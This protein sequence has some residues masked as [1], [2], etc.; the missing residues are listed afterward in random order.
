VVACCNENRLTPGTSFRQVVC[1]N[2]RRHPKLPALYLSLACN[3]CEAP[4][5]LENCPTGAYVK[6]PATGAVTIDPEVC[7][8]CKYCT[9]TCPYDAPRFNP[10]K[11]YTEKCNFCQDRLHQGRPPACVAGCPTDALQ[12]ESFEP[13]TAYPLQHKIPG[14]TAAPTKPS[15]RLTDWQPAGHVV[16]TTHAPATDILTDLYNAL[17]TTER[18]KIDPRTEWTLLVFTLVAAFQ[19]AFVSAFVI[20]GRPLSLTVFLLSGGFNLALSTLHLGRKHR[21][22][23]A[24]KKTANSWLSREILLYGLFMAA[25]WLALTS[26]S[27]HFALNALVLGIGGFFLI[28]VDGVYAVIPRTEKSV[29]DNAQITLTGLIGALLLNHMVLPALVLAA[30]RSLHFLTKT[31]RCRPHL[32]RYWW[33]MTGL[34]LFFGILAP[35]GFYLA[36]SGGGWLLASMAAAEGIDRLWFYLDIDVSTPN[37]QMA[38]DFDKALE[39]VS[40]DNP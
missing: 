30:F 14:F 35:L 29:L 16:S 40:V 11:G 3:H 8:G 1:Y 12:I 6:D 17:P 36:A 28:A 22:Y 26:P 34:R 4:A 21:A 13:G 31:Q 2:D 5:C 24:L 20:S 33:W 7:I 18:P 27:P 19:V 38:R 10:V 23:R 9:L 37:N 25:A 15:V 39:D 32:N